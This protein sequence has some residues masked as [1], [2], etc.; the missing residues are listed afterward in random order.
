MTAR[1]NGQSFLVI[2][3]WAKLPYFS[4]L[5]DFNL[6]KG[7]NRKMME[8]YYGRCFLLRRIL[9]KGSC[10]ARAKSI[11]LILTCIQNLE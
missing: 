9:K 4:A 7:R 6:A 2:M 10:E 3:V 1:A 8:L 11:I 5:Q